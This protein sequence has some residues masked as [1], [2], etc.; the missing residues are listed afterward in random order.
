MLV[1]EVQET[2]VTCTFEEYRALA[3][4]IDVMSLKCYYNIL[5]RHKFDM[6]FRPY[7][8]ISSSS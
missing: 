3:I 5:K 4:S 1:W 6:D 8:F 2:E 7:I